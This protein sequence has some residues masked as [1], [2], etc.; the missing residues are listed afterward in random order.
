MPFWDPQVL[1]ISSKECSGIDVAWE[2]MQQYQAKARA[3]GALDD[4]RRTQREAL[5]WSQVTDMV[6]RRMRNHSAVATALAQL[7]ADPTLPASACAD[8]LVDLF[9][10]N[11]NARTRGD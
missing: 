2:T 6:V 1:A 3:C 8:T 7:R 10:D 9:V 5:M 4:R 11:S